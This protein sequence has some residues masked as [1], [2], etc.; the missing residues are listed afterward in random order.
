MHLLFATGNNDFPKKHLKHYWWK[1]APVSVFSRKKKMLWRNNGSGAVT[2]TIGLYAICALTTMKWKMRLSKELCTELK[3]NQTFFLPPFQICNHS[4][5][6]VKS[7]NSSND[8]SHSFWVT[9]SPLWTTRVDAKREMFQWV[10]EAKKN[11]TSLLQLLCVTACACTL[12]HFWTLWQTVAWGKGGWDPW[13]SYCWIF[14]CWVL[15][16]QLITHQGHPA[17]AEWDISHT[18]PNPHPCRIGIFRQN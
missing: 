17:T 10:G 3:V 7:P 15:D 18:Y 6:Y 11:P 9:F 1:D 12:I 2:Q 4:S 14:Y 16:S 5:I 13:A 8:P